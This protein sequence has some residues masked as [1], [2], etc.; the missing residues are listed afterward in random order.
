MQKN[1]PKLPPF[2]S[3]EELI[4]QF[5][6]IFLSALCWGLFLQ[7]YPAAPD[8]LP[9]H[10]NLEGQAD[11][12]GSKSGLVFLPIMSSLICIGFIFLARFPHLFNFPVQI[13]DENAQ[14]QYKKAKIVLSTVGALCVALFTLL[15]SKLLTPLPDGREHLGIFFYVLLGAI[16]ATPIGLVLF[17]KKSA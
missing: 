11:R 9:V 5:A 4:V 15:I 12:Y 3:N 1:Q 16:V 8:Q 10:F 17:W 7:Q 13:T 6:M 14:F 2:Y